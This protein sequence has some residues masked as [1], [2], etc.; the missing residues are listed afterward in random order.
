MVGMV[1]MLLTRIVDGERIQEGAVK[2]EV[3]Y[4]KIISDIL[5]SGG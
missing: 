5:N 2:D 4:L 1:A 3:L